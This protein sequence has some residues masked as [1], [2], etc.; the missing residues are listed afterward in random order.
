MFELVPTPPAASSRAAAPPADAEAQAP[1]AELVRST[2]AYR[3]RVRELEA[4]NDS[5]R[6]EVELEARRVQAV[7]RELALAAD[8][9]GDQPLAR[10]IRTAA[11]GPAGLASV[12]ACGLHAEHACALH[13]EPACARCCGLAPVRC[14]SPRE[15]EVLRLLTEGS[16]SPCIAEQLGISL[17]TVEVHRRNIMRKL[18]LHSVAALTKYAVREGLTSL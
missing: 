5:L 18:G 4:V 10:V 9:V 11:S 3:S 7:M 13:G 15:R 6:R 1:I 17:A 2:Q 14:L 16:R 8:R 12:A